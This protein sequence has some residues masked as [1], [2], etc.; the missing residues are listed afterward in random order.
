MNRQL[1]L[2]C[3]WLIAL[4]ALLVTLYSSIFLKMAPCHLCWYQRI[5][6]YPLVIILGIGAYQ[7]D[8]RSAVYGLPLAVIGALLAL[9]QYL[10]QW[11]PALESIG[12][13]GQGPSCSDI[14]IKYWGFITYPFISLIGFLLIVGLL[15]IWGRKHAV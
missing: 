7:D 5:C 1:A 3:A 9:Y 6:I 12:V 13:C 8:P 11:Y 10:M 15:A 14:N 4:V 2:C